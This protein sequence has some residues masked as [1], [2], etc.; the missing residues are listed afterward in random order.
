M[1]F[2]W[3]FFFCPSFDILL[4]VPF[5]A[6]W[7][8]L[9]YFKTQTIFFLVFIVSLTTSSA[10]LKTPYSK[11]DSH[12]IWFAVLVSCELNSESR[13]ACLEKKI[14]QFWLMWWGKFCNI[15]ECLFNLW[16]FLYFEQQWKITKGK[17]P[18]LLRIIARILKN[19]LRKK[20]RP[21]LCA[22]WRVYA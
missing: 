7:P 20:S 22:S 2:C 1:C 9:V 4:F 3:H 8:S 5:I 12:G 11:A 6:L 18:V 13:S 19:S 17:N 10:T 21:T 15:S 16:L 14:M